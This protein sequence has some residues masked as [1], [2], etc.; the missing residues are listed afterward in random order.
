MEEEA[1]ESKPASVVVP[2]V[3]NEGEG[4]AVSVDESQITTTKPPKKG[5]AKASGNCVPDAF[6]WTVDEVASWVEDIGFWQYKVGSRKNFIFL[7]VI[8]YFIKI[9]IVKFN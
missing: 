6:Y 1:K 3:A 2:S 5:V 9:F 8:A 4:S 7:I